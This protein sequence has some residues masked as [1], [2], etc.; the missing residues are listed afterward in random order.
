MKKLIILALCAFA[1]S[2]CASSGAGTAGQTTG[3]IIRAPYDFVSG[4]VRGIGGKG[5]MPL[6]EFR[7]DW[8]V[9]EQ[10]PIFWEREEEF[11]SSVD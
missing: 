11:F 3:N 2:S 10:D 6:R 8:S 7:Q 5:R 1:L 4:L 9:S